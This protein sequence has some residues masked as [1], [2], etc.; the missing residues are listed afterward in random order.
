MPK[1]GGLEQLADLRRG[2]ARKRGAVFLEGGVDTPMPTMAKKNQCL[3][4]HFFP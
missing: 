3:E 4:N 1:N 2:F